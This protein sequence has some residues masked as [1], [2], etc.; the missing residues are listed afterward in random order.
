M[1]LSKIKILK[2]LMKLYKVE[3]IPPSAKKDQR[4]SPRPA[5]NLPYSRTKAHRRTG[6]LSG[7]QTDEV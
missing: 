7:I 6:A 2:D 5:T 1:L 4:E 3:K